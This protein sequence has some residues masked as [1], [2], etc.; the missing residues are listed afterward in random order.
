MRQ[1]QDEPE[2][3]VFFFLNH[4][5]KVEAH[6]W[7]WA[8]AARRDDCEAAVL[9]PGFCREHQP[10]NDCLTEI[11]CSNPTHHFMCCY[12]NSKSDSHFKVQLAQPDINPGTKKEIWRW[13]TYV[14]RMVPVEFLWMELFGIEVSL[15]LDEQ[16]LDVICWVISMFDV[17]D[18]FGPTGISWMQQNDCKWG[19]VW[20]FNKVCRGPQRPFRLRTLRCW[21][22]LTG[23]WG[24]AKGINQM[25]IFTPALVLFSNEITNSFV[26]KHSKPVGLE[27]HMAACPSLLCL[28]VWK[29]VRRGKL[30]WNR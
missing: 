12:W 10:K 8:P 22:A 19:E 18:V 1:T 26:D 20:L 11:R 14:E 29:Y 30:N 7:K 13:A 24:R 17:L 4:W 6:W 25:L 27:S 21:F 28:H 15:I 5:N 16:C 3:R 2:S 23:S 9:S